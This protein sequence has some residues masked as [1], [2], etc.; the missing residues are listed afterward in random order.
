M[1][2]KKEHMEK[3]MQQDDRP[4]LEMLADQVTPLWRYVLAWDSLEKFRLSYEE[5]LKKKWD[6]MAKELSFLRRSLQNLPGITEKSRAQIA[7]T[8]GK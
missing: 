6:G 7:W 8:A 5:Q 2:R 4:P 1:A 3:A